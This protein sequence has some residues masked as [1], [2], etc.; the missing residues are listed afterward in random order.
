MLGPRHYFFFRYWA[1]FLCKN[2]NLALFMERYAL[3]IGKKQKRS[4]K[5]KKKDKEDKKLTKKIKEM[6]KPKK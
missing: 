4:G 6:K 1:A 3:C 2:S 5:P